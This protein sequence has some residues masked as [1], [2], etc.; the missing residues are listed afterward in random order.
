MRSGYRFNNKADWIFENRIKLMESGPAD[1]IVALIERDAVS[2]PPINAPNYLAVNYKVLGMKTASH[3]MREV[4]L[5]SNKFAILDVYILRYI[6]EFGV[7]SKLPRDKR[8]RIRQPYRNEYLG[9][10]QED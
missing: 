9:Y 3:F 6:E 2:M 5:S 4:G 10:E 7:V 1:G 8:G